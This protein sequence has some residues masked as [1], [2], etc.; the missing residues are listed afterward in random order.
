M[1]WS[2]L[3]SDSVS[4]IMDRPGKY[5]RTWCSSSIAVA[6]RAAAHSLP[7]QLADRPPSGLPMS[8]S[9]SWSFSHDGDAEDSGAGGATSKKL[10]RRRRCRRPGEAGRTTP[11]GGWTARV[12]RRVRD[13]GSLVSSSRVASSRNRSSTY[14]DNVKC[15]ERE[16]SLTRLYHFWRPEIK[17]VLSRA[18]LVMVVM[19]ILLRIF[20]LQLLNQ[21]VVRDLLEDLVCPNQCC[22]F[23]NISFGGRRG[24]SVS[25][26]LR[27]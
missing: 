20:V 26:S 11:C 14:I 25:G 18:F 2:N 19:F 4:S 8:S 27:P 10:T 16:F 3:P 5:R 12:T 21:I 23:I 7:V 6:D 17:N 13:G 24:G 15:N 1:F 22:G 9:S